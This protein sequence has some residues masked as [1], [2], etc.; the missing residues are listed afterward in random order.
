MPG[1]CRV[2]VPTALAPADV[3]GS[4]GAVAYGAAARC[5]INNTGTTTLAEVTIDLRG[6]SKRNVV[7]G[8]TDQP[9]GD[10]L[11]IPGEIRPGRSATF[12]L[13]SCYR[14]GDVEDRASVEV[15]ARARSIG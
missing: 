11:S 8:L 9:T 7:V 3:P 15:V 1:S 4:A 10:S 12:Y 5:T 14:Q 2:D 6:A 13:R